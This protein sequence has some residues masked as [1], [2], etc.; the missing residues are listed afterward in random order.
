MAGYLALDLCPMCAFIVCFKIWLT[1]FYVVFLV[2]SAWDVAAEVS[3]V[4]NR[5]CVGSFVVVVVAVAVDLVLF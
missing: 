3:A 2:L 1:Y 5:E 4:A